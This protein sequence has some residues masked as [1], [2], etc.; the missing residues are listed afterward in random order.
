MTSKMSFWLA[1]FVLEY[2]LQPGFAVA[3]RVGYTSTSFEG[4]AFR[5]LP[6]SVELEA[7]GMSGLL[8]GAEVEKS[9]YSRESYSLDIVGQ[10]LASLGFNKK[11][12]IPG[13][14]VEGSVQGKPTWMRASLGP[15]LTYRGWAGVVPFLY[16]RFDYLWGK[17]KLDENIQELQGSEEKDVK[18]KAKFGIGLGADFQI[19]TRL[20]LRGEAALYPRGGGT[21]YSFMVRTLFAL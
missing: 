20:H 19:S 9:L 21:D 1:G 5:R 7:G 18:G 4:L 8:L 14:A 6:L 3:A 12:A 11:W 15:V 16:P 13:L 10:F 2:R 17:F